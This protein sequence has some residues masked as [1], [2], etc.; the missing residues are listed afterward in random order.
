MGITY[1]QFIR[2]T[3]PKHKLGAQQLFRTLYERGDIYL[4]SYTGQYSIGEEMFVD[5]PPG[6]IGPD[7]RP[8]SKVFGSI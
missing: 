4:S 6:T 2:T 8:A 5:G 7:G 3:D 1:D